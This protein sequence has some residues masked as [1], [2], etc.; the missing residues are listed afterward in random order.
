M[1]V[2]KFGQKKFC[3]KLFQFKQTLPIKFLSKM[4][5]VKKSISLKLNFG[6]PVLD[7]K[8]LLPNFQVKLARNKKTTVGPISNLRESKKTLQ[9]WAFG[10]T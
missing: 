10:L 4:F 7:K 2:K 6:Q 8:I 1:H 3:L 9:T 5:W